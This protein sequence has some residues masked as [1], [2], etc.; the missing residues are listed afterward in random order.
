MMRLPPM[1]TRTYTLFPYTAL[2][3][4]GIDSGTGSSGLYSSHS[5]GR[6]RGGSACACSPD[7]SM[8]SRAV[9]A[10][11]PVGAV[12]QATASDTV[13]RIAVSTI[14]CQRTIVSEH[15]SPPVISTSPGAILAG[16]ACSCA[17]EDAN[18]IAHTAPKPA[19]AHSAAGGTPTRT[20]PPP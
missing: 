7:T 1:F 6:V 12:N 8:N 9:R 14:D 15:G 18:H 11:S 19:P 4:C 17:A 10:A 5:P 13:I 16:L 20:A 3:R 2:F